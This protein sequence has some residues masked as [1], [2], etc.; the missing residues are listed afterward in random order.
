MN[1]DYIDEFIALSQYESYSDTAQRLSM[2]QPTLSKHIAKLESDLG[3]KLVART[4][5]VTLTSA[6]YLFLEGIS[7]L[8][9]SLDELIQNCRIAN[10]NQTAE[11]KI[12]NYPFDSY[13]QRF[14]L[15]SMDE[16]L[17]NSPNFRVR[18]VDLEGAKEAEALEKGTVDIS[19]L[20][21]YGELSECLAN[22]EER[23]LSAI[24]IIR[25]FDTLAMRSNNPLASLDSV[26]IENLKDAP[27][28]FNNLGISADSLKSA[29]K[30]MCQEAGFDPIFN[31]RSYVFAND[32]LAL[33]PGS[34]VYLVTNTTTTSF[35]EARPSMVLRKLSNGDNS[36]RIWAFFVYQQDNESAALKKFTSILKDKAYEALLAKS[37]T[38]DSAAESSAVSTK[39]N[40]CEED[41]TD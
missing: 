32:F 22:I 19:F 21:D 4:V 3:F 15:S 24:P 1:T 13:I 34:A 29:I 11:L 14:I 37:P 27:I 10:S 41:T 5:P 8:R 9:S 39:G 2:S 38:I 28:M 7:P 12:Q 30:K 17:C 40:T 18:T 26:A 33:D 16:I 23:G 36:H 20:F 35:F 31:N 25:D 6:G